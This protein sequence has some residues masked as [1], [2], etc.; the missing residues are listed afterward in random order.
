M[1]T[2]HMEQ[3]A[4]GEEHGKG[5]NREPGRD[6]SRDRKGQKDMNN[7]G[8]EEKRETTGS[9][10]S[11]VHTLLPISTYGSP[12]RSLG[13]SGLCLTTGRS[14]HFKVYPSQ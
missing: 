11:W 1:M 4:R 5:N 8:E 7:W 3:A 14:L 12:Q 6:V 9:T 10:G 2:R 13:A